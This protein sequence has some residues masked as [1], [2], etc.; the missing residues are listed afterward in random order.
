MQINPGTMSDPV[1]GCEYL[2]QWQFET[3]KSDLLKSV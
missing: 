2:Q 3:Y 1:Y